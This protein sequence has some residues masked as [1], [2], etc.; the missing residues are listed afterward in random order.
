MI[1]RGGTVSVKV[2]LAVT[3]RAMVV[4]AVREPEDPVMVTVAEPTVAVLL[5]VN[6]STLVV[7]VG[8]V[9]YATVTPVGR[10][11]AARVTEPA[12]GLTSVTEIVS[13]PPAP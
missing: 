11:E 4:V 1:V 6:V 3:V 13:A 12:N 2:G 10:P 7:A 8:L 5:A 9:P